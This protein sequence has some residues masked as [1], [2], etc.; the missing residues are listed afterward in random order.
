MRIICLFGEQHSGKS[1]V[2]QELEHNHNFVR[3]SFA[4]PIRRMLAVIMDP[5]HLSPF[6]DKNLPLEDFFGVSSREACKTLGTEWGRT[7]IHPDIWVEYLKK[8]IRKEN[9]Q[10]VVIDDARFNNEYNSL[11]KE[12]AKFI[13]IHRPGI[14]Q[15]KNHA[16]EV[17]W[18]HWEPDYDLINENKTPEELAEEILKNS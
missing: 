5:K 7:L 10:N 4:L 14:S 8:E 17:D 18:R 13:K 15:I 11:K 9:L 6:A 2:A 12:N 1:T 3:L 16:S